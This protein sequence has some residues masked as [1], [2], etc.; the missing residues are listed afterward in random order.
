MFTGPPKERLLKRHRLRNC[1]KLLPFC[2]IL[3]CGVA[4]ADYP[5]PLTMVGAT[6]L[7][8]YP[9]DSYP[10]PLAGEVNAATIVNRRIYF[11][12]AA[13]FWYARRPDTGRVTDSLTYVSL[14]G[15]VGYIKPSSRMYWGLVAGVFVPLIAQ[16]RAANGDVYSPDT[17][18]LTYRGRLIVGMRVQSWLCLTA[19]VGYRLMALGT[20]TGAGGSF[21]QTL[22][23]FFVGAGFSFTL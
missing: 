20:Y 7:L 5:L 4:R 15:E 10:L 9:V 13:D 11:G 8:Y 1:L 22:T 3:L 23:T 17:L 6:G 19:T 14:G 21:T 2:A 12:A 18:A 16:V